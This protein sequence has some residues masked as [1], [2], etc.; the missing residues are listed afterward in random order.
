M[1]SNKNFNT[2]IKQK[3]IKMCTDILQYG[4]Q[5]GVSIKHY[6]IKFIDKF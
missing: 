4:N 5:I 2:K 6:S 3:D 1:L